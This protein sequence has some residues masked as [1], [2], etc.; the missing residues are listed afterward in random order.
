MRWSGSGGGVG[1]VGYLASLFPADPAPGVP[2][3]PGLFGP[4]SEVWRIGRERVLLAAGPAALLLQLAHP[5]VAAGVG[6]HSG[7]R[8][9]PLHRLRATLD[10]TLTVVFGDRGQAAAAAARVRARHRHVAG[11]IGTAVG[12]FPAG[13]AYRAEDPQ[14]ALWVHATLVWT[15]LELYDGFIAPLTLQRRAG[16]QA[17]MSRFGRLFGVPEE[18]LP[19]SHADLERYV[20]CMD[21]DGVLEVGPQARALAGEILSAGASGL[22]W[23]LNIGAGGL[24]GVL[25]AGLLPPRL[26]A[27]YR[28]SWGWREQQAFSAARLVTRTA[29]PALPAHVRYWPHYLSAQ[30]RLQPLLR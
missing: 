5:L 7:F 11:R 15:A 6:Q 20:R 13:T 24:T 14:L 1:P 25:A 17:E 21:E 18:L 12:G 23:P 9:D 26:R 2:G 16:Y 27:G 30:R 29:V 22:A 28:L 10:A 3:D 19:R 8:A 4:G